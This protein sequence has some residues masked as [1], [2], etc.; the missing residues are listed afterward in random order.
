MYYIES[1]LE[2]KLFRQYFKTFKEGQDH[3]KVL[4]KEFSSNVLIKAESNDWKIPDE[5]IGTV[6]HEPPIELPDEIPF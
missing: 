4:S 6:F 5:V 3:A 2:G 1:N